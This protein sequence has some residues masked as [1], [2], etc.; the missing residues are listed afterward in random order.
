MAMPAADINY[1]AVFVAAVISMAIG[2]AWYSPALFGVEWMTLSGIKE[3]DIEKAKEK[4]MGKSYLAGFIGALV[5]SV[6]LAHFIDF[7]RA[8]TFREGL[9]AGF[10]IW[11]G[12]VAPVILGT[13]LWE[14]KPTRLYIINISYWLLSLS[15]MGGILAIWV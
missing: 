6:V 2:A 14:A 9:S 1:L 11:L 3:K 7:T 12:F 13:V 4:G 8:T 15:L 5:M 10:W